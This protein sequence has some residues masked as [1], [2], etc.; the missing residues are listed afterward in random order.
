MYPLQL[1]HHTDT[2]KYTV[3]FLPGGGMSHITAALNL[4]KSHLNFRAEQDL[5]PVQG[6]ACRHLGAELDFFPKKK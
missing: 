2:T 1:H 4:S 3:A 5:M 6:D